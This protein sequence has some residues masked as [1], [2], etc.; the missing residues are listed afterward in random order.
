MQPIDLSSFSV[1]KTL[2]VQHFGSVEELRTVQ[3]TQNAQIDSLVYEM[4]EAD[5]FNL[6]PNINF[7]DLIKI[8]VSV[9]GHRREYLYED[10]VS[11]I[12]KSS[13]PLSPWEV[14]VLLRLQCTRVENA[15]RLHLFVHSSSNVK[16]SMGV[17]ILEYEND[18]TP[19]L[20]WV[21]PSLIKTEHV[22]PHYALNVEDDIVLVKGYR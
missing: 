20:K 21:D 22:D 14:G 1:W 5:G 11:K 19:S 10:I 2:T 13:L 8:P 17:H 16:V 12:Q 9:F 6:P 7:I 4:F 15:D 18:N 3:A